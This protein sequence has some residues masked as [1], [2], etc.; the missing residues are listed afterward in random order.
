MQQ[1]A[2]NY[3]QKPLD[4]AQLRVVTEK[5]AESARLRRTNE[6]M[7]V[8]AH[9]WSRLG[10]RLDVLLQTNQDK[11]VNALDKLNDTVTRV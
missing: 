6:E 1:G 2:F 11:L 5:A 3:L 10:E 4:L 9:N 8:A 7:Q